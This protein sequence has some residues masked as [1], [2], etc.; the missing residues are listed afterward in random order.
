MNSIPEGVTITERGWPGHFIG[1]SRCI[2][3]RNTLVYVNDTRCAVV[4]TVGNM[5]DRGVLQEIGNDRWVETCTFAAHREGAYLEADV[6][7][8][9]YEFSDDH[10]HWYPGIDHPDGGDNVSN[11]I[12]DRMVILVAEWL[13][14]LTDE[15]FK[16]L[17][18]KDA[19]DEEW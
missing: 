3:R 13:I 7:R 10:D 11:D 8:Q 16:A 2:F 14:A 4:S 6:S 17:F 9:L 15:D 18:K 1:A 5:Q 12:H 19:A